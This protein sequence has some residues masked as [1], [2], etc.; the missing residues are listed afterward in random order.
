VRHVPSRVLKITSVRRLRGRTRHTVPPDGTCR[1]AWHPPSLPHHLPALLLL[2]FTAIPFS[3]RGAYTHWHTVAA[4]P[5]CIYCF[6]RNM[7]AIRR[8]ASRIEPWARRAEFY[9]ILNKTTGTI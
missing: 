7:L 1:V 4:Q 5:A 2:V 8:P 9:T 3:S 6:A